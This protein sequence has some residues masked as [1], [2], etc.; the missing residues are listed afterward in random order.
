MTPDDFLSSAE[1]RSVMRRLAIFQLEN[2]GTATFEYI[3]RDEPVGI[4][5]AS[6]G[7]D[8]TERAAMKFEETL[9]VVEPVTN[10]VL[11][12]FKEVAPTELGID[13]GLKFSAKAGI[14]FTSAD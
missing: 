9:T 6:V 1:R 2:G 13:F 8:V 11:K 7:S 14:V 12:A 10:A 5:R 4:E 3:D